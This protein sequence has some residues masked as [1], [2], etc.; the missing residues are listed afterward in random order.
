MAMHKQLRTTKK[1]VE[2]VMNTVIK[3]VYTPINDADINIKD[4]FK[5][6]MTTTLS[7]IKRNKEIIKLGYFNGRLSREF[8][9]PLLG[10]IY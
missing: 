1:G 9:I 7:K 5:N 10:E 6:K 4:K 2:A 3:I 8:K